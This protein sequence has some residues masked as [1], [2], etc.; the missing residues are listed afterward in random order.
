MPKDYSNYL[1][2]RKVLDDIVHDLLAPHFSQ[3][4]GFVNFIDCLNFYVS[5]NFQFNYAGPKEDILIRLCSMA[6]KPDNL[7]RLFNATM[8][9]CGSMKKLI[10]MN[11]DR[12]IGKVPEERS[13]RLNVAL[14]NL[15]D[16]INYCELH[17]TNDYYPKV[18]SVSVRGPSIL[19][20][21]I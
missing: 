6:R 9:N 11:L 18:S 8:G 17:Y 4:T 20:L 12:I 2:R 1:Q 13:P 21:N 10:T 7:E 3:P 16:A 19:G 15:R 5:T 14:C